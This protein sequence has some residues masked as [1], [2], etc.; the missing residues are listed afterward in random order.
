MIIYIQKVS[1]GV[2]ITAI[3]MI[4]IIESK[5]EQPVV[6]VK[7]CRFHSG[8][9]KEENAGIAWLRIRFYYLQMSRI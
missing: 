7:V 2:F 5:Y 8:K 4:E 1:Q 6:K 9:K 3:S